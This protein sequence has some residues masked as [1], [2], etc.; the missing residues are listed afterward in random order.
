[1]QLVCQ[2]YIFPMVNNVLNLF[3]LQKWAPFLDNWAKSHLGASSAVY[4]FCIEKPIK[5]FQIIH[6]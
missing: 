3:R 2:A 1:M 4:S 6:L 5:Y